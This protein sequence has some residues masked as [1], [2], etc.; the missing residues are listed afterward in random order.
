MEYKISN[1]EKHVQFLYD[2]LEMKE[3]EIDEYKQSLDD[4]NESGVISQP[5]F[6][7]DKSLFDNFQFWINAAT[8]TSENI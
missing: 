6:L 5:L 3:K 2:E 7:L 4:A 8:Y 1:L